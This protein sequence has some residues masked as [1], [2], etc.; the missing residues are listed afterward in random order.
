MLFSLFFH[1]SSQ[2]FVRNL[3]LFQTWYWFMSHDQFLTRH[4]WHHITL[5]GKQNVKHLNEICLTFFESWK[6]VV[7]KFLFIISEMWGSHG[8]EEVDCC[9]LDCLVYGYQYFVGMFQ[10][11][12]QGEFIPT[13]YLSKMSVMTC[14]T[15]WCYKQITLDT[16]IYK[17]KQWVS[18]NWSPYP[19]DAVTFCLSV[20]SYKLFQVVVLW[21]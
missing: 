3:C 13:I 19:S 4:S 9:L 21:C 1:N 5:P 12:L 14:K 10:L 15:T 8:G 11:Y 16:Y 7:K 18:F 6:A 2:E 20:L 17:L